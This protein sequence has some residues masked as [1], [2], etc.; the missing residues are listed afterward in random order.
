MPY[1]MKFMV[2][3]W[4]AFLA[5]VNPV[6]TIAKPACMNITRNPAT[7]VQTKLMATVF[8]AD[9][10]LAAWAS[11]SAAGTPCAASAGG[12][13]AANSTPRATEP[14]IQ[15]PGQGV[16]SA[17]L[18]LISCIKCTNLMTLRNH[19]FGLVRVGVSP[20]VLFEH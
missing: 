13:A 15:S 19:L 3:V 7:S 4:A 2:M 9:A 8:A 1:T 12:H 14:L 18:S 16:K 6:S 5:R 17:P 10:A 20:F 11:E